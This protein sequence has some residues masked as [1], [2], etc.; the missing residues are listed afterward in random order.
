MS[1]LSVPSKAFMFIFRCGTF[2]YIFAKHRAAFTCPG[3]DT[4]NK[5]YLL[6]LALGAANI[7]CLAGTVFKKIMLC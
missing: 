7:A 6:S 4:I 1:P 2:A 5:F 3:G